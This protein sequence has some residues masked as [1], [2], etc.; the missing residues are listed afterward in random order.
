MTT[1]TQQLMTHLVAKMP[2]YTSRIENHLNRRHIIVPV[3]MMLPGVHNGSRGPLYHPAEELEASARR[4]NGFPVTISHPV[5]EEG[6]FIS[7]QSAGSWVVG[8]IHNSRF[9][10]GKLKAEAWIDEQRLLAVSTDAS[11]AIQSGQPLDVSIGAYT[12]EVQESGTWNGKTYTAIAR[13]HRPDHLA[14][15]PGEKGACSWADGCGVRVNA[16]SENATNVESDQ[17]ITNMKGGSNVMTEEKDILATIKQLS[18]EGFAVNMITNATGFQETMTSLQQKLDSMDSEGKSHYL[19]E[20]YDDYVIYELGKRNPNG[21]PERAL[22]KQ[23]YEIQDNGVVE[24]TGNPVEVRRKVEYVTLSMQRTKFNSN[25]VEPNNDKE[26]STTHSP[27]LVAKVDALINNSA[28]RFAEADRDWLLTQ[29]EDVLAKLIPVEQAQ[30]AAPQVN[31]E[32]ALAV[33]KESYKKPEE[34]ISVLP[35]DL[36]TK[37]EEGL[38]LYAA[39]R[40]ALVKTIKD[41]SKEWT[42]EELGEMS[43]NM[44]NKIAKTI[45][46]QTDYS[47]NG[48]GGSGG[49]NAGEEVMLPAGIEMKK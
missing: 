2:A 47:V 11:A 23:S 15:L 31:V 35:D 16:A 12:D 27:C 45:T 41:A 19:Q 49:Q 28:T 9:E 40:E 43:V 36:K 33:L 25:N 42:D 37:V 18:T 6:N 46:P 3:V 20:V 26:M 8:S 21:A 4:W 38:K 14:L 48:A 7:A 13:N 10:D 1:E 24:L 32:Q 44:L 29:T 17:V 30:P 5:D 22:Y 34:F 39:N